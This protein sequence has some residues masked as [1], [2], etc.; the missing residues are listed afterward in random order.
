MGSGAERDTVSDLNYGCIVHTY[1]TTLPLDEFHPLIGMSA[2]H[3]GTPQPRAELE[4]GDEWREKY[5]YIPFHFSPQ[6]PL[7]FLNTDLVPH[8]KFAPYSYSLHDD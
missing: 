5:L 8:Q 7:V 2:A 1:D 4:Q 3:L 6:N